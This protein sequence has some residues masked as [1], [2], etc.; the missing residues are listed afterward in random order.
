MHITLTKAEAFK[1]LADYIGQDNCSIAIGDFF[2]GGQF[3]ESGTILAALTFCIKKYRGEA[4]TWE[5]NGNKIAC[6]KEFRE[7]SRT[8]NKGTPFCLALTN[9]C[10]TNPVEAKEYY[11][12][13]GSLDGFNGKEM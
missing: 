13:H 1:I 7:L 3:D 5:G 9:E 12:E 4:N 2:V 6:I 8:Y 11:T 10:V